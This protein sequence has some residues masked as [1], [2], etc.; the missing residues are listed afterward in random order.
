MVDMSPPGRKSAGLG[1]RG[2]RLGVVCRRVGRLGRKV[3][4]NLGS[5]SQSGLQ[6][7]DQ[8]ITSTLGL[9]PG[10][11]L[12]V[13]TGSPALHHAPSLLPEGGGRST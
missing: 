1:L 7:G 11:G 13:F 9:L 6:V 10:I 8:G 2:V 3:R 12:V 5:R 4:L